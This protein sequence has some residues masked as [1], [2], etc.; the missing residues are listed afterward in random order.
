MDDV[1]GSVN[2]VK[3]KPIRVKTQE[4]LRET[5]RVERPKEDEGLTGFVLGF[6]ASDIEERFA[7]ALYKNK[8]V[9]SFEFQIQH[10]AGKNIPGEIRLDFMVHSGFDY[11]IMIDGEYAHKS[12]DAKAHDQVQRERLDMILMGTGALPTQG[13]DGTKLQTQEEADALVRRMF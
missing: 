7:R 4:R 6:K 5:G 10:Y 12:A 8:R 1:E 3:L 2:H 9:D 13:I 11:P